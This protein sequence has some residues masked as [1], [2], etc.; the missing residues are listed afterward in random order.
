M[1]KYTRQAA[2]ATPEHP[3]M[4]ISY[5]HGSPEKPERPRC[6]S[7]A[8]STESDQLDLQTAP[9]YG[10]QKLGEREGLKR[11][12]EFLGGNGD[13]GHQLNDLDKS[14]QG[15]AALS[16]K[17]SNEETPAPTEV[18]ESDRKKRKIS[19]YPDPIDVGA[20]TT[21]NESMCV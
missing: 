9:G 21:D 11:K 6:Q 15:R 18:G 4:I 5:E 10:P 14:L 7:G 1:E 2:N 13:E 8:M 3:R 12:G 19:N 16:S 17:A 20:E